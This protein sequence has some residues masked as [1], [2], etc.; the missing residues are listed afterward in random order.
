MRLLRYFVIAAL[1][2]SVSACGPAS[3]EP[4]KASQLPPMPDIAPEKSGATLRQEG[5]QNFDAGKYEAAADSFEGALQADEGDDKA[6]LG[7]AESYLKLGKNDKAY[8]TFQ[9]LM[10]SKNY[11]PVV[12]QGMGLVALQQGSFDAAEKSLKQALDLDKT[13]PWRSWNGLGQ[14]YDFAETVDAVKRRLPAGAEI[15]AEAIFYIQQHGRLLYGAE[16]VQKGG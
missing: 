9:G 6:R 13:L 4:P 12:A 16:R 15:H 2:G 11:A 8:D 10:L 3:V 1:L 7:L 14:V 5:Q